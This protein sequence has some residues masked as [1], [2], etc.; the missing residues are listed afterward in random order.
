MTKAKISKPEEVK[1]P[2]TVYI[3]NDV[4]TDYRFS[5]Q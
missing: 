3:V 4:F 2:D 5:H 1:L